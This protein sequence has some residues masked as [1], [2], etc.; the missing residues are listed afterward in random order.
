LNH[1]DHV[2][3][4][5][6]GVEPGGIWADL[7]SG[8]GAFTLALADLL[9]RGAEIHSVDRDAAALRYQ[10]V[11]MRARFP[12]AQ[13]TYHTADFTQ[14]LNAP[15]LRGIV[16]ANAL[17]FVRDAAPVLRAL[18]GLLEPE[19]RLV[20]VEYEAEHGNQ[21]VPYPISYRRWEKLAP[22][23]GFGDV[24]RLAEYP[25]R[26]MTGIYSALAVKL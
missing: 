12:E 3:L 16:I 19:G 1:A 26:F 24:R 23:C 9:G 8:R 22:S 7:G 2:A 5:R 11:E 14:P 18:H 13:V 20:L 25:S 6:P 4:L 17:H 21:W 10:A 15:P